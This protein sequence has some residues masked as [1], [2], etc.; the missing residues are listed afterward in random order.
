MG[1]SDEK[2]WKKTP[3]KNVKQSADKSTKTSTLTSK[4][5]DK[6]NIGKN[7]TNV[8]EKSDKNVTKKSFN[9]KF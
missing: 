9:L 7:M 6:K 2:C 3:N 1:K 4:I 8:F 5:F